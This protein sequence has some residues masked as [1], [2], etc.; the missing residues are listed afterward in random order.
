MKDIQA[1]LGLKKEKFNFR[2]GD[3]VKVHTKVVEGES[4]RIQVFDGVVISRRGSGIAETI[5]VR[6]ISYGVGVERIFPI[7]SP[8]IDKIE[9]VKAGKVRRSKIYYL[10]ELAGKSAR[11]EE[12]IQKETATELPSAATEAPAAVPAVTAQAPVPSDTKI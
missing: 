6:K 11:L 10:R 5:T 4:E 2:T 7:N 3:T 12:N 9:V 1:H 8:R